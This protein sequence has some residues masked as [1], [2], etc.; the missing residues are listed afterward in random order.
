[1]RFKTTDS[2]ANLRRLMG[3]QASGLAPKLK[4]CLT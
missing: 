1:L 2:L 4:H 3:W